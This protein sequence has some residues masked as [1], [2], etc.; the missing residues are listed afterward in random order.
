[1]QVAHNKGRRLETVAGGP[2]PLPKRTQAPLKIAEV[3]RVY[4]FV[5]EKKSRQ[6]RTR[7]PSRFSGILVIAVFSSLV[8]AMT[9]T[10]ADACHALL[11]YGLYLHAYRISI[12]CGIPWE[13]EAHETC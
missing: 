7:H 5:C 1:M 11:L 4:H 6:I 3:A 13:E 10:T 9:S 2:M 12:W 8:W